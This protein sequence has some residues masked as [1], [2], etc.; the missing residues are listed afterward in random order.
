MCLFSITLSFSSEA[1]DT[2]VSDPTEASRARDAENQPPAVA[3]KALAQPPLP[4]S[5]PPS[6]V[7]APVAS[8]GGAQP[9]FFV[10]R[11]RVV[12]G[13]SLIPQVAV[14]EAVYPYLGPYRTVQDVEQA[15]AA[16]ETAYHAQGFQT[17]SVIIPR[18]ESPHGVI[19][20]QVV[21]VTVGRLRVHGSRYFS[22][23]AIKKEVPSLAE[24]TVPNFN[25]VSPQIVALNQSADLR[26]TPT[27]RAGEIPG[28]VDVDLDVK[29]TPPLHGSVEVNNR[30]SADTDPLRVNG[31]VSYDNL[32]QL[33]HSIGFSF[34]VSPQDPSEVKVFS[35]D[36]IMRFPQLSWLSL[37]FEGTDQQSNVSTLGGIGVAG[38]GDVAGM[39]AIFN[40]PV[41]KDF[42]HSVSIG[43]DYKHF[44]QS[45]LFAG[46]SEVS[47]ITY[48]PIGASYSATWKDNHSLTEANASVDFAL[49]E[50]G[51][52]ESE[53]DN[54]RFG[55]SG[56][57]AYVRGDL[58]R[59]QDLPWNFQFYGKVQ[60]QAASEPLPDAE[61]FSGGG[62]STVRGYLESE[63][64]GDHALAA[65][66]ELRSPSLSEVLG[67]SVNDWRF[68][69]FSDAA[70]MA[71]DDPL[72]EQK[73]ST[74]LE[75]VG[76]GTRLQL[77]DHVNASL[78]VG[79]ALAN[80]PSTHAG[81]YLL[82][83]RF[84]LEF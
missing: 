42:Y 31:S 81:N 76:A 38:R 60:G 50:L 28:T 80:G 84:W 48:V 82:T 1:S 29:D 23:D 77:A 17:V 43:F 70:Y 5:I 26:V 54:R 20:L 72:P 40:L 19:T 4:P 68:Y 63:A 69:V 30:Y 44:D 3:E 49:R 55:S 15:R 51:S 2:A 74:A 83:F 11:Y 22:L 78:D 62:L 12:G 34:Q 58:A 10:R 52:G 61:Q 14:E 32:W 45:I 71:I 16:L 37:L 59:T 6:T 18:Q 64:L 24:G 7:P 73:S 9:H 75:S 46:S 53:F 13:R 36:Y 27:L 8:T 67:K 57:F 35:A 56:N 65:S 41:L 66:G 33:G 25:D 79:R 21:P 39:K 47:P